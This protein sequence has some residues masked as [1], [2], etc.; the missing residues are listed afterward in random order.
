M[1]KISLFLTALVLTACQQ[2]PQPAP[3]PTTAAIDKANQK[4]RAIEYHC[5]N[6]IVVRVTQVRGSKAKNKNPSI[7]VTFNNITQ[8]L[9][10]A[11]SETG[12]NY[13]NIR[14]LWQ[15][16]ND[17]STL[18]TSVGAILAEQCVLAKQ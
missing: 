13:S 18:R 8:K 1:R 11:I 16:R 12:K 9:Q 15:Q 4:S 14:W 17:Y 7:N 6:D 10:P 5:K 2:A 3:T